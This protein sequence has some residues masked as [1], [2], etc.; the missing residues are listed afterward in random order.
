MHRFDLSWWLDTDAY[1]P[2]DSGG[3]DPFADFERR[4]GRMRTSVKEYLGGLMREEYFV[5]VAQL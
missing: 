2:A 3:Y 5:E 1:F 4:G